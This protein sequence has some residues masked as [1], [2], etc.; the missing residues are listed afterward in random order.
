MGPERTE[1]PFVKVASK[2]GSL[3]FASLEKKIQEEVGPARVEL[4]TFSDFSATKFVRTPF[5]ACKRDVITT[6]LRAHA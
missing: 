4:A 5:H 2:Q 1:T 3:A 6:K